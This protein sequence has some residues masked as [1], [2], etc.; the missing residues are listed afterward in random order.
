MDLHV[1]TTHVL[2]LRSA[3][4]PWQ[5]LFQ[6]VRLTGSGNRP[7]IEPAP[8]AL[9]AQSPNH[10]P[11]GNPLK[12][13]SFHRFLARSDFHLNLCQE[14][15]RKIS[16]VNGMDDVLTVGQWSLPLHSAL[17]SMWNHVQGS[18]ESM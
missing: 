5:I 3:G 10:V 11:L 12:T 2:E 13:I 9:K 4:C 6:A 7:G 14:T 17:P 15:I 8:W 18:P 1:F 16:L